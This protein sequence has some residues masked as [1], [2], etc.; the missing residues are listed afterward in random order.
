[1]SV[2][3]PRPRVGLWLACGGLAILA[4]HHWLIAYQPRLT[5]D[6]LLMLGGALTGYLALAAGLMLTFGR[7]RSSRAP[8]MPLNLREPVDFRDAESPSADNRPAPDRLALLRDLIQRF[9]SWCAEEPPRKSDWSAFDQLVREMLAEHFE[10]GRVRCFHVEPRE[11]KLC[12]LS[13][14]P[15][16][17]DTRGARDGI[18]GHVAV[19]GT[20][21]FAY[22]PA[23]GELLAQLAG[24]GAE[25]WDWVI[26]IRRGGLAIGLIAVGKLANHAVL[27]SEFRRDL[28]RL[29]SL[30]W[31]MVSYRSQLGVAETTDKAS[32]L[33]TRGDF[34]ALA[35]EALAAAY[36]ENEPVVAT[37]LVLEGLRRLDDA[38]RWTDRDR[39]VENIGQLINRRIRTDD[40]I[41]RFADDRFV[42][43]LRRLDSG[44]GRLIAMK[45]QA[46]VRAEIA[47]LG[48]LG[49]GLNVRIGL[50]GSGFAKEPLEK[51][52]ARAFDAVDHARKQGLDIYT[53]LGDGPG[54]DV[55][56]A[57][58]RPAVTA[59]TEY[60]T[61]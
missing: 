2:L 7:R 59:A 26:P 45:V 48:E 10:V 40:V 9:L 30:A 49:A 6:H 47:K 19:T 37:V 44:L 17:S 3:D 42:L 61:T 5:L 51:L 23:Q 46:A 43:L 36:A 54:S 21:Y 56:H 22:D 55:P 25:T 31:E 8:T 60:T 11:Q 12:A 33:L 50:T 15:Q 27:T 1:M 24:N 16:A 13:S 41:G 39:L 53:D 4:A 18:L 20:E 32:G 58:A 28:I 14:A 57:A 52:L 29:L 38:G 35:T 34:F